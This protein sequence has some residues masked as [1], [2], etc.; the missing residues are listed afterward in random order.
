MS[1]PIYHHQNK[2]N[3]TLEEILDVIS[4][5]TSDM[6][7]NTFYI[8]LTEMVPWGIWQGSE[9]W[10]LSTFGIGPG[11]Q[12]ERVTKWPSFLSQSRSAPLFHLRI[13]PFFVVC[14]VQTGSI[15][16]KRTRQKVEEKKMCN[17]KPGESKLTSKLSIPQMISALNYDMNNPR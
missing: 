1:L 12:N 14:P 7:I 11:P 3:K 8:W 4:Q 5:P 15:K 16:E 10:V 6:W 17:K 9:S 13:Y 2:Q